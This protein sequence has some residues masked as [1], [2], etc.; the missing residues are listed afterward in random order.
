[1]TSSVGGTLDVRRKWPWRNAE[2]LV[3]ELLTE[4]IE[5]SREEAERA[6]RLTEAVHEQFPPDET[7][8][9]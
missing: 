5:E 4:A 1:M 7:A 9:A 6:Q 8:T 2:T 3:I